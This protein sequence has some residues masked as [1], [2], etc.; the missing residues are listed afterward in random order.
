[1]KDHESIVWQTNPSRKT[2]KPF[3]NAAGGLK[4]LWRAVLVLLLLVLIVWTLKEYFIQ[5]FEPLGQVSI[6]NNQWLDQEIILD[7]LALDETTTFWQASA[8]QLSYDLLQLA[9]LH[10]ARVL[11]KPPNRLEIWVLE[12]RPIAEVLIGDQIFWLDEQGILL[13]PKA[14][15]PA[16]LPKIVLSTNNSA[17]RPVIREGV[18]VQ[19]AYLK[20]AFALLNITKRHSF[21]EQ[22]PVQTIDLQDLTSIR[23]LLGNSLIIHWGKDNFEMKMQNLDYALP[24]LLAAR[25]RLRKVDL[26]YKNRVIFRTQ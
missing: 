12:R 23:F 13:E 16:G 10:E 1:M 19:S 6:H 22:N 7:Q 25:G 14:Q 26:R 18:S 5:M 21:F 17:T 2:T 8:Y 20:Q 4:R 15:T 9:W 24:K 3:V 11:K